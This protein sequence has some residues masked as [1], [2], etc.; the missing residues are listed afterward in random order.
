MALWRR[1]F[2]WRPVRIGLTQY[3][4]VWLRWTERKIF[5]DYGT[6]TGPEWRYRLPDP[7]RRGET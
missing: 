6:H 1:W 7:R 4:W 3:R 2:A 5:D